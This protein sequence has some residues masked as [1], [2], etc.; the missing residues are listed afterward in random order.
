[1][2]KKTPMETCRRET[3]ARA[4]AENQSQVEQP[5]PRLREA[6]RIEIDGTRAERTDG[7]EGSD[8]WQ[9]RLLGGNGGRAGRKSDEM[10][11]EKKLR[12]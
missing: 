4:R 12:F 9:R 11:R 7:D 6:Q 3:N 10:K 8:D 1:M 5:S 2:H